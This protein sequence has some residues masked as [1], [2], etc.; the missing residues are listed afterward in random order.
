MAA[1]ARAGILIAPRLWRLL[2]CPSLGFILDSGPPSRVFLQA[3][4]LS[5]ETQERERILYQFSKRF[6]YCNP[7]VFSSAGRKGLALK[8][9]QGGPGVPGRG[10]HGSVPWSTQEF[11]G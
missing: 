3:L 5:G 7:G 9:G 2:C 1:L 6:H 8:A 4:V 11:T 10:L